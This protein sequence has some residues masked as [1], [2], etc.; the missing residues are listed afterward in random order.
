MEQQAST[1][2]QSAYLLQTRH[3]ILNLASV[4]SRYKHMSELKVN[5]RVLMVGYYQFNEP[6]KH[7]EEFLMT[8]A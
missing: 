7:S 1:S 2:G 6:H 5:S 4:E 8:H 3:P